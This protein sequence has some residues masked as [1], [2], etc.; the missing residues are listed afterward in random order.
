MVF[1]LLNAAAG[2]QNVGSP[3]RLIDLVTN[4]PHSSRH[5]WATSRLPI[6]DLS[7]PQPI[8]GSRFGYMH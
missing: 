1:K 6:E 8:A 4:L 7:A 3:R 5:C 2:H